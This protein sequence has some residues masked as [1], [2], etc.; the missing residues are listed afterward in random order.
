MS[1]FGQWAEYLSQLP[2]C[3]CGLPDDVLIPASHAR[4]YSS[5]VLGRHRVHVLQAEEQAYDDLE[6]R[7]KEVR[8]SRAQARGVQRSQDA[9]PQQVIAGWHR[10]QIAVR[11]SLGASRTRLRQLTWCLAN[12]LPGWSSERG[13]PFCRCFGFAC[14]VVC[15]T[16]PQISQGRLVTKTEPP[17]L[18][19]TLSTRLPTG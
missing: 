17:F 1:S 6:A 15:S 8:S 14:A 12:I 16:Q 5:R 7:A 19:D 4:Q 18:A 9:A 3:P 13:L 11:E 2:L 10:L